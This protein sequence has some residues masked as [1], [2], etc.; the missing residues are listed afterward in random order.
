MILCHQPFLDFFFCFVIFFV[1]LFSSMTIV[2]LGGGD[3]L[4]RLTVPILVHCFFGM[5]FLL[6]LVE[7][8]STNVM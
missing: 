8:S 3:S 4:V 1:V 2:G 7:C 6:G 5:G